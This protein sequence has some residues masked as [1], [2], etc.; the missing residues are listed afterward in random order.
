MNFMNFKTL[1]LFLVI[2][3][4]SNVYAKV[5]RVNNN[6]GVTADFTQ[7]STAVASP[8]VQNGDTIYLESSATNYFG[9]TFN[10]RLVTIGAGYL[11]NENTGLQATANS[12]VIDFLQLD[13]LASGS[14]FY[15]IRIGQFFANSNA[16]NIT[17]SRCYVTLSQNNFFANS[18]MSGWNINKSILA[19]VNFGSNYTFENLQLT[20]CIAISTFNIVSNINGLLRNNLF[21]NNV[22]ISNCYVTNNIFISAFSTLTF[23]N[24]TVKY[25]IAQANVLP[26]GNNNQNNVSQASLFLLTGST[27]ARYQLAPGSPAIAAGEPINGETPDCGPFGTADPYRISG[28]PPIPTIYQLTVPASIPSSSTTMTVTV[29]TRSNN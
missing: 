10:K 1:L 9:T 16:D 6:A 17:I 18:R 21:N 26:A 12:T 15:G 4:S 19:N 25:N 3:L 23:T 2:S 22:T 8:L 13:S 5:W 14:S 28:I 29:S 11:L 20:N 27:D 24:C 7:L